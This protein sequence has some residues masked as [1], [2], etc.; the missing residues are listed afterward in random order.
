MRLGQLTQQRTE[1]LTRGAIRTITPGSAFIHALIHIDRPS[2]TVVVR[3][4]STS[5]RS[6]E[7]AYI[8]LP[9]GIALNPHG[10]TSAERKRWQALQLLKRTGRDHLAETERLLGDGRL[11]HAE[12]LRLLMRFIDSG[13]S[14]KACRKFGSILEDSGVR[15]ATHAIDHL[16]RQRTL[17]TL[18]ATWDDEPGRIALRLMM[19]SS[20]AGELADVMA[21]TEAER[22]SLA[23]MPENLR[24]SDA[25][26]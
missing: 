12:A 22:T 26:P 13:L 17:G 2:V 1:S 19:A 9:P 10:E 4:D 11:S 7:P 6:P 3:T 20:N 15:S 23:A 21:L 8:F 18:S 24:T 25:S 14:A 5:A 16:L